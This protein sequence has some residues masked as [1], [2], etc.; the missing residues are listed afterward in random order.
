MRSQLRR[1]R[2]LNMGMS[3]K[4][5]EREKIGALSGTAAEAI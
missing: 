5:N 1:E 3:K 4:K 2:L